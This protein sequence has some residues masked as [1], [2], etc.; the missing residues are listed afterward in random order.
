MSELRSVDD[1]LRIL[2]WA[3]AHGA[4]DIAVGDVKVTLPVKGR[5]FPKWDGVMPPIPEGYRVSATGGW[6][7]D[8]EAKRSRGV[9]EGAV[10]Q[11]LA[12]R[13]AEEEQELGRAGLPEFRDVEDILE[14]EEAAEKGRVLPTAEQKEDPAVSGKE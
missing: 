6:E 7:I 1:I 2:E 8:P 12:A 13:R 4:L 10:M 5:D 14:A 9:T 3:H 11:E